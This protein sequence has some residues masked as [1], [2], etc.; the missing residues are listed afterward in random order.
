MCNV[1]AHA[2]AGQR[3][4]WDHLKRAYFRSLKTCI[5]TST[6]SGLMVMTITIIELTP[7]LIFAHSSGFSECDAVL[8]S[9][10]ETCKCTNNWTYSYIFIAAIFWTFSFGA[11]AWKFW[12]TNQT[13][14]KRR[15][16]RRS[17]RVVESEKTISPKLCEAIFDLITHCN[18]GDIVFLFSLVH[19][20]GMKW[21]FCWLMI[22]SE[23]SEKM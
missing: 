3:L 11:R 10:D 18:F 7:R 17:H 14:L 13:K 21:I 22:Q 4:L 1:S 23:C 16:Q 6:S 8:T 19:L 12:K 2:S 20:L 5:D 9:V 15:E